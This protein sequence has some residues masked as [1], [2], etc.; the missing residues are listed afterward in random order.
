VPAVV[1]V[2]AVAGVALLV[3]SLYLLKR[4]EPKA[5]EIGSSL[6]T[7]ALVAVALSGLQLYL[8]DRREDQNRREQFRTTIGVTRHLEGL[9]PEFTLAGMQLSQKVLDS[10]RLGGEDLRAT[11]FQNASL[12][13]AQLDGADLRDANLNG[14]ILTDADLTDAKMN[15]ADLRATTLDATIYG[16][17]DL[18]GAKADAKTCWPA[19]LLTSKNEPWTT[20][21]RQVQRTTLVRHGQQVAGKSLGRAC[22]VTTNDLW[23]AATQ[24]K[25]VG[26]TVDWFAEKLRWSRTKVLDLLRPRRLRNP[27][28]W[29][30]PSIKGKLCAGSGTIA[31]DMRRWWHG[32]SFVTVK[33]QGDMAPDA[34]FIGLKQMA[35]PRIRLAQPL[36]NRAKVAVFGESQSE[37]PS[38]YRVVRR[39]RKCRRTARS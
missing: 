21:R 18:S 17:G 11:N 33:D 35:R 16:V 25:R 30:S 7:G 23:D 9:D 15:D 22:A 24:Y 38:R 14:A 39:V 13:N 19:D 3:L 29:K 10:A 28:G 31:L 34:R 27:A 1:W 26:V 4:D 2:L 37:V 36:K 8:E 32:F 5:N 12:K 6:L 20:M